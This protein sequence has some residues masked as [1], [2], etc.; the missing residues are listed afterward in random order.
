MKT[1]SEQ[2]SSDMNR[3]NRNNWKWAFYFN[4]KDRRVIVPK[5]NPGLGWTLNFASPYT[6]IL[7]VI[8][9]AIV[10]ASQYLK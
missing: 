2:N 10:V 5:A 8:V 6:Y 3:K 7:L 1:T 4:N 9:I